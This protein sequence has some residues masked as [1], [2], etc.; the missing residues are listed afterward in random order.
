M[1]MNDYDDDDDHDDDHY[2]D[3][4]DGDNGLFPS[5]CLS[6]FRSES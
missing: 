6:R 5:C 4:G 3:D 1:V 2:D